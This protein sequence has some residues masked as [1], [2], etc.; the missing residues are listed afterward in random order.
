MAHP[1]KPSGSRL[2]SS[3]L[4]LVKG[5]VPSLGVDRIRELEALVQYRLATGRAEATS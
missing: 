2:V 4:F 3:C 1:T 5:G